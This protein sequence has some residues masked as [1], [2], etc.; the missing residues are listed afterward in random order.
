MNPGGISGPLDVL[1]QLARKSPPVERCELCSVAVAEGHPHLLEVK[2]RRLYCACSACAI[3]FSG[4]GTHRYKRV[5]QQSR[6]LA[7]FRLNDAQ[8]ESLT[9]PINMAF[10]FESSPQ[11]RVV[12]LYP[13]PAG[14][15][16]SLLP[17]E[18]WCE[19]LDENPEL[20]RMEADV[21]ALLV[22]RLGPSRGFPEHEYYML[23]IDE[24]FRLVGLIRAHWRGLSGGTE[25][26]SE[27][28]KFFAGLKL[29][30][31]VVSGSAHA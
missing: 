11:S 20:R 25:M 21:E 1:R 2:T 26:W 5:P 29:R 31:G 15:T 17:V 3:L 4:N 7:G 23:P 18:A 22:N 13:S 8:W 28:E 9:I 24:C 16:E 14:A 12:A 19:I 27:I 10:F 30:S 6:Y